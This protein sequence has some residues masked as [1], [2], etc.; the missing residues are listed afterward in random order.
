MS[1][2]GTGAIEKDVTNPKYASRY[3]ETQSNRA[4]KKASH[5]E[6]KKNY[7]RRTK[8]G[9]LGPRPGGVDDQIQL[10]ANPDNWFFQLAFRLRKTNRMSTIDRSASGKILSEL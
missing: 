1:V 2:G 3:R 10:F 6:Y 4:S 5:P 8:N 9:V 7:V